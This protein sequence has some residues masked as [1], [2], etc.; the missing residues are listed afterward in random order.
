MD[1]DR[2]VK[3]IKLLLKFIDFVFT[4]GIS[5]KQYINLK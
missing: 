4:L 3:V 1:R 5:Y 2:P